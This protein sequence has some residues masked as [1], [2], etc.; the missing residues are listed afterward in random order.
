[1]LTPLDLERI[2]ASLRKPDGWIELATIALC[3]AIAWAVDRRVH[4]TSERESRVAQLGAGSFNRMIFPLTALALLYVARAIFRHWQ[5]PVFF[6]IALPLALALALIRLS[7]Y[8]LRNIFGVHAA[9]ASERTLSFAIWGALLLYY[10]GVLPDIAAA[11]DDT[12]IPIGKGGQISILDLG[13]DAIVIV[14]VVV[15][16]LWVSSL[17]EQRL[18]RGTHLDQN[19]RVVLAKVFR[20]LLLLI[21]LLVA[22][23][24]VGVDLTVLSVF[25]GAVGVG[26]GLGLQKLASN[27]IAGFTI[28]LDRSIR[29]GDMITVDNRTGTVSVVTSRYVVVAASTASRRSCRTRCW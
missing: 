27:Y 7:I 10:V 11:L 6:P 16:S 1:M 18:M 29:L 24:F 17:L 25:G 4:V 15:L 19:L 20:A 28:L 22:L 5:V 26:I 2:Q 14:V 8:A 23:S 3:F 9:P 21:G 13:R 12:R